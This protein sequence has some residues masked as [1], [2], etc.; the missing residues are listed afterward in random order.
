[1]VPTS[2]TTTLALSNAWGLD[3]PGRHRIQSRMD[4]QFTCANALT[5]CTGPNCGWLTHGIIDV[6]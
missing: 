3:V 1:M 2:G 4:A 6:P 5:S